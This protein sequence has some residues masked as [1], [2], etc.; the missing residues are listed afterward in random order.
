MVLYCCTTNKGKLREFLQASRQAGL[1]IKPLQ[2]LRSIPAPEE[3][4][5]TFEENARIKALAYSLHTTGLVLADDSGLEVD[6]L[7]GAPGVRSARYAGEHAS[8]SDNNALLLRELEGSA[9]RRAQFVS[10]ISLAQTG[11]LIHSTRGT[12]KGEILHEPRGQNGF[13]YDALFFCPVIGKTLGEATDNEKLQVSHRGA[14]LRSLL[15]W[16]VA[17]AFDPK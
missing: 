16:I 11:R 13:G 9:D 1:E 6:V 4:G 14:A 2:N 7:D 8:D 5:K 17:T 12:V 10:V 3:T 15:Q